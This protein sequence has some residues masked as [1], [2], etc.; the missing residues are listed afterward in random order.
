MMW[1]DAP[2][3]GSQTRIRV[4]VAPAFERLLTG[5]IS[6]AEAAQGACPIAG[7]IP[8]QQ[9]FMV[10]ANTD[11][12]GGNVSSAASMPRDEVSSQG[13]ATAAASGGCSISQAATGSGIT[14]AA[15]AAPDS[16]QQISDLMDEPGTKAAVSKPAVAAAPAGRA[17][18]RVVVPE[19]A[20][21]AWWPAP[22]NGKLNLRYAGEAAFTGAIVLLFDGA[23]ENSDGANQNIQVKDRSG[24]AVKGTWLVSA[25]RQ[26]LLFGAPPGLYSVNVRSGLADKGGR[27]LSV[28]SEGPV[29]VQ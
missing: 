21:K 1:L 6:N 16:P 19:S 14:V 15:A 24:R 17:K 4:E 22:V 26:M 11:A 29:F 23:F 20:K 9:P 13:A 12:V 25:N 18:P 8:A 7:A 28:P 2:T 5:F 27:K 10:A 3:S